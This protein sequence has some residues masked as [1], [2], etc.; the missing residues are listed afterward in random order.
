MDPIFGIDFGTTRSS[1]AWVRPDGQAEVLE[2]DE[3]ETR[4]PSLVYFGD[5]ET[6]VGRLAERRLEDNDR[7]AIS[8][9]AW[10][11]KRLLATN[12]PL[13]FRPNGKAIRPSDVVVEILKKL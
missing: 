11:S 2:N 3:G 6:L 12:A 4:T 5:H 13:P 8:R 1:M 10:S 7:E 9:L